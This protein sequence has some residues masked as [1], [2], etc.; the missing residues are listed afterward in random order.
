MDPSGNSYSDPGTGG[1][2][3]MTVGAIDNCLTI[4]APG[5]SLAHNHSVDIIAEDVQ[6]LIGW[7]ARLNYDGGKM[8]LQTVNFAPFTDTLRGQNVSFPNLPIDAT[9]DLHREVVPGRNI[10]APAP[11]PQTALIGAV[12]SGPQNFPISPDTPAKSPLDDGSY[13]A[14]AG[15][16]LAR[17]TLGVEAGNAG[18]PSLLMNLDDASPNLPGLGSNVLVFTDSGMTEID[19]APGALGDGYHGEGATCVPLDCV[20]QECALRPA[21]LTFTLQMDRQHGRY[22]AS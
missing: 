20:T 6:D 9:T 7:Q 14:P 12:Y 15:G 3:S 21:A 22:P 4:A 10:P 13:S 5:N 17:V 1:D 19:L 2:N 18:D 8:R 11:G 16:V